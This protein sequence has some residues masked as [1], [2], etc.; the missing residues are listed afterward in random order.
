MQAFNILP[1]TFTLPLVREPNNFQYSR[2]DDGD[3]IAT[4]GTTYAGKLLMGEIY[5]KK[6]HNSS[7]V[8]KKGSWQSKFAKPSHHQGV[9]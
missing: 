7:V 9:L 4:D 2:S 1:G 5:A 3:S 8:S 6:I